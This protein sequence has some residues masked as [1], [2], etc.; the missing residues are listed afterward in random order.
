[1]N[2]KILFTTN[3]NKFKLFNYKKLKSEND[4]NIIPFYKI[5]FYNLGKFEHFLKRIKEN[6]VENKFLC[7]IDA[8]S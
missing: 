4:N 2:I 6:K 7:N 5:Y 3:K 1:L 8:N